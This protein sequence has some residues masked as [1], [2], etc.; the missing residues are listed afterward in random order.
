M[1]IMIL[2]EENDVLLVHKHINSH[3]RTMRIDDK[4]QNILL[5]NIHMFLYL[6]KYK[7]E[8]F[9]CGQPN[10]SLYVLASKNPDI[11]SI[12][13]NKEP[14][15]TLPFITEYNGILCTG[16]SYDYTF[17]QNINDL[18]NFLI[19]EFY[20]YKYH[21]GIKTSKNSKIFNDYTSIK[22]IDDYFFND[23]HNYEILY[24]W[25]FYLYKDDLL[26]DEDIEEFYK[27]RFE[28]AEK[29]KLKIF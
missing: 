25:N 2:K 28:Y 10:N 23:N 21:T 29:Q 14:L 12:I 5:P 1:L 13:E 22:T 9:Y 8:Y 11:Q 24:D 26:T 7:N 4:L 3:R 18:Y 16:H 17:H 6:K 19:N 20:S 27:I 15:S